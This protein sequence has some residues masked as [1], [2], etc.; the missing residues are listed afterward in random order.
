VLLPRED[1]PSAQP[2]LSDRN[3]AS[4]HKEETMVG[5]ILKASVIVAL[6]LSSGVAFADDPTGVLLQQRGHRR[7]PGSGHTFSDVGPCG[8]GTQSQAFPN[9]QGF[10]CVPKR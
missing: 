7:A 6:A 10:R 8:A 1:E 4:T 5:R 2:L 3:C 9:A